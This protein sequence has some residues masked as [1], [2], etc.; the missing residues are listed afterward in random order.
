MDKR[1]VTDGQE[2]EIGRMLRDMEGR[3][4]SGNPPWDFVKPR[5]EALAKGQDYVPGQAQRP[6][7]DLAEEQRAWFEDWYRKHRLW[8]PVPKPAVSN[9]EF[10]RKARQGKVLCYRP[11]TN[12][13]SY[14]AF[15]NAVGQG[16]NWTVK[17]E[18]ERVKIGWEPTEQGYWFWAEAQKDCL[19]LETC[20]NDLSAS[21][22][23]LAL[24]EYVILWH[25]HKAKT[26]GEMLDVHTWCWL[27]TCSERSALLADESDE[28]V[29]VSRYDGSEHLALH[30]GLEGGR[31]SEVIKNAA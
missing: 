4:L 8:I 18:G 6:K 13:V 29:N 27:R 19:R 3:L 22:K 15:M 17:D 11:A 23:L 1:V 14:E 2:L 16:D 12:E 9:R 30:D 5:L 25:A 28:C 31:V 10:N 21:I 26:G 20:W 24:E 7:R